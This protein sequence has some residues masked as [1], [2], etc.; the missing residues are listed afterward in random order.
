MC[1]ISALLRIFSHTVQLI[2]YHTVLLCA[3]FINQKHEKL[4][5]K[6]T[7]FTPL[8]RD[9]NSVWYF[10]LNWKEA[11]KNFSFFKSTLLHSK[12]CLSFGRRNIKIKAF[13][14]EKEAHPIKPSSTSGV[15]F[16]KSIFLQNWRN[17]LNLHVLT[18]TLIFTAFLVPK[19]HFLCSR[20]I[21]EYSRPTKL[22]E[23]T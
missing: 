10:D 16:P 22:L 4:E 19:V 5:G 21:F 8:K 9:K 13:T 14:D 2:F 11:N 6:S 1:P 23:I 15:F 12:F 7:H 20:L 17:L 3:L 18:L